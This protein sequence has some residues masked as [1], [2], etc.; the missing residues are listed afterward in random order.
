MDRR[1]YELRHLIFFKIFYEFGQYS[2][3]RSIENDSIISLFLQCSR[4]SFS[5][6]YCHT[7]WD[8]KVLKDFPKDKSLRPNEWT[9]EFYLDFFD[10]IGPKILEVVEDSRLKGRVSGASMQHLWLLSQRMIIWNRQMI[11]S[12]FHF[13]TK[14]TRS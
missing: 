6:W 3:H 4:R 2:Y 9:V 12:P 10:L 7:G 8:K 14:S 11:F 5:S 13:V 1:S